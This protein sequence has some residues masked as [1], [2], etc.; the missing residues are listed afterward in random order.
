MAKSQKDSIF[1]DESRYRS[2]LNLLLRGVNKGTIGMAFRV[3]GLLKVAKSNRLGDYSYVDA[4]AI[5]AVMADLVSPLALAEDGIVHAFFNTSKD[6]FPA[7]PCRFEGFPADAAHVQMGRY[8]SATSTKGVSA[9]NLDDMGNDV[10]TSITKDI[11]A[12]T[13][14]PPPAVAVHN[15]VI[16]AGATIAKKM[17]NTSVKEVLKALP[18]LK[19]RKGFIL[20]QDTT[21]IFV[22][23]EKEGTLWFAFLNDDNWIITD[24]KI[25]NPMFKEG[26]SVFTLNP[27][28]YELKE[29]LA[30]SGDVMTPVQLEDDDE[31]VESLFVNFMEGAFTKLGYRLD[32]TTLA[33]TP[34]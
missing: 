30:R 25:S 7:Q 16:T 29:I 8:Y 32:K 19:S 1:A 4:N 26:V 6:I 12:D 18:N 13:V 24:S 33:I 11:P 22:P 15:S 23:P 28:K 21:T 2:F 34:A 27:G 14:F 3:S 20:T 10:Y 17:G 9:F 5:T 31:N